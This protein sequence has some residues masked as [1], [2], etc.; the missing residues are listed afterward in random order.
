MV[1]KSKNYFSLF[2]ICI[3]LLSSGCSDDNSTKA[4]NNA[5]DKFNTIYFKTVED[6]DT[7]NSM[8]LLE[9]LQENGKKKNIEELGKLLESIKEN[10]PKNKEI[11]YEKSFKK[12]YDD[13][14]LLKDSYSKLNELETDE[15]QKVYWA[16]IDMGVN[17]ENWKQKRINW[18]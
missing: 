9:S 1:Y 11:M 18:K 10:I 6:L 2:I 16:L 5:A 17:I 12:R 3:L 14:V 13:L 4:Y 7:S 15:R 8:K